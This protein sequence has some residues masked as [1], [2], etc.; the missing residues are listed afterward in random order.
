VKLSASN[1]ALTARGSGLF[2]KVLIPFLQKQGLIF[3]DDGV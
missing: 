3:S 2:G 1:V